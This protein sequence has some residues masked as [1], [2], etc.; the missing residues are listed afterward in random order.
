MRICRRSNCQTEKENE[1]REGHENWPRAEPL[2]MQRCAV[3]NSMP[4]R[5][6]D[7]VRLACSVWKTRAGAKSNTPIGQERRNDM[8]GVRR[9]RRGKGPLQGTS[10]PRVR[11]RRPPYSRTAE[12]IVEPK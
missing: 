3:S 7:F 12:Q 10:L 9:R 6:A 1:G 2:E 5:V 11:T 4:I 8:K